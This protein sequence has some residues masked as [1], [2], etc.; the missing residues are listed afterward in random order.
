MMLGI[1]LYRGKPTPPP[2]PHRE[3]YMSLAEARAYLWLT[4]QELRTA[5]R[6][7]GVKFTLFGWPDACWHRSPYLSLDNVQRLNRHLKNR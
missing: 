5:C 7:I 3:G 1:P 6:Q 4:H 2:T